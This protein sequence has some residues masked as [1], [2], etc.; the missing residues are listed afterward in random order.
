[1]VERNGVAERL[2]VDPGSRY[3][4][5]DYADPDND[6]AY[7][8]E[9]EAASRTIDTGVAPVFGRADAVGQAAAAEAVRTAAA[10]GTTVTLAA[11][12]ATGETS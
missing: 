12:T 9:L 3:G 6:D 1:V 5:V 7:R 4:L 2:P 11:P 10:T 8:I